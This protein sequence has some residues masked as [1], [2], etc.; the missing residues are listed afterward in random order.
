VQ[1]ARRAVALSMLMLIQYE[2]EQGGILPGAFPPLL[3][4]ALALALALSLPQSS[5]ARVDMTHAS[6]SVI[7]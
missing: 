7:K 6:T 2:G 1:N 3:A 4:L 5:L